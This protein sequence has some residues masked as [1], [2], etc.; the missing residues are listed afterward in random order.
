MKRLVWLMLA[1]LPCWA[2]PQKGDPVEVLHAFMV[3]LATLAEACPAGAGSTPQDV[4]QWN[5][6]AKDLAHRIDEAADPYRDRPDLWSLTIVRAYEDC[7][8]ST[9]SLATALVYRNSSFWGQQVN[10]DLE[11]L[12]T[13]VHYLLDLPKPQG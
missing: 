1:M 7:R 3:E 2:A 4:A 9:E 13:T 5:A 10:I 6:K 12:Q 8:R 11:S